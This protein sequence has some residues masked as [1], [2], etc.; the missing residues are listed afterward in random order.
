MHIEDQ[1]KVLVLKTS[2][3]QFDSLPATRDVDLGYIQALGEVLL[4]I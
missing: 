4:R 2:G 1:S 3:V